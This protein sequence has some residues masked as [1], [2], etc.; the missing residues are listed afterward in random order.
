V[1]VLIALAAGDLDSARAVVKQDEPQIDPERC[2]PSMAYYQDLY[3]VLDDE[4]QRQVL[5]AHA[6]AFDNDRGGWGIVRAEIYQ[7]RGDRARAR[8]TPTRRDRRSW[9]RLAPTRRRATPGAAGTRR[10]LSGT[11][12][13]CGR[14]MGSPE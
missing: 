11:Q 14:E 1:K 8:S 5:A 4:Q 12:G 2:C 13:R 3:W 9:S 7:L 10:G 6:S